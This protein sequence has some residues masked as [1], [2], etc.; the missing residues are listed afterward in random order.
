MGIETTSKLLFQLKLKLRTGIQAFKMIISTKLKVPS[1]EGKLCSEGNFQTSKKD[2]AYV[3]ILNVII[4]ITLMALPGI[5]SYYGHAW[6]IFRKNSWQLEL[7]YNENYLA[8]LCLMP[9]ETKERI[10]IFLN[11]S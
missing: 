5:F 4:I 10:Y 3:F 7:A 8:E 2:L 1:Q 6:N 11:F 9:K